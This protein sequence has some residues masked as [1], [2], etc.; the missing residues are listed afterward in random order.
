MNRT[1]WKSPRRLRI[2]ERLVSAMMTHGYGLDTAKTEVTSRAVLEVRDM[3]KG[4]DDANGAPVALGYIRCAHDLVLQRG[5]HPDLE[6]VL[7]LAQVLL[8]ESSEQKL[9]V[10]EASLSVVEERLTQ[11]MRRR[12]EP[13]DA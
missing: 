3:L 7:K 9:A 12:L 2:A 6:T 8:T 10:V 11:R 1:D 4:R 5:G 13:V